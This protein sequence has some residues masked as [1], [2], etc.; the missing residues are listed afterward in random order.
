M[1][2]RSASSQRLM[3]TAEV[4]LVFCLVHLAYRSFKETSWGRLESEWK[5]LF[6]MGFIMALATI[7]LVKLRGGRPKDYGLTASPFLPNLKVG[8]FFLTMF[9]LVGGALLGLGFPLRPQDLGP[10]G[11]VF[12]A[13]LGMA[14]TCG[15]LWALKRRPDLLGGVPAGVAVALLLA[16]LAAPLLAALLREREVGPVALGVLWR[17]VAVGI[18]EELFFRGYIQSRLNVVYGRPWQLLGVQFGM[19]LVISTLLFAFIHAL[20][21]VNY[22]SGSYDFAWGHGLVALTIHYGFMR[23]MT[24]SVLPCIVFHGLLNVAAIVPSM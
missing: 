20:N 8:L 3:G 1:H 14:L 7:A 15:L 13:L 18:G 16:I 6:S 24:G 5:L 23:E 11:G 12:C 17:V 9:L 22:F 19:G 10:A 21:P 2:S 4:L